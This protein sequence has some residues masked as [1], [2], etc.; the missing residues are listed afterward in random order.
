MAS[1][2]PA[3]KKGSAAL[4][5]TGGGAGIVAGVGS[6]AE[7]DGARALVL[8]LR[9]NALPVAARD[10]LARLALGSPAA[11]ALLAEPEPPVVVDGP[12]APMRAAGSTAP[13]A[14]ALAAA[15]ATVRLARGAAH[16]LAVRSLLRKFNVPLAL[17]DLEFS[18][19]KAPAGQRRPR[20]IFAPGGAGGPLAVIAGSSAADAVF[21]FKGGAK[22][23]DIDIFCTVPVGEAIHAWLYKGKAALFGS[24]S[25]E[26][27]YV[28]SGQRQLSTCAKS[29]SVGAAPL[30]LSPPTRLM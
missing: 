5:S 18:D 25:Q 7:F 9:G 22:P 19:P 26:G 29:C 3:A 20:R 11:R 13:R 28:G 24:D 30:T 2:G 12:P 14:A 1:S 23:N 15:K 17:L 16:A 8:L 4:G 27:T 21:P 6:G 10:R